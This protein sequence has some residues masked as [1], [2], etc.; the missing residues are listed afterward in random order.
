M[1]HIIFLFL[2][3]IGSVQMNGQTKPAYDSTLAKKLGADDYGMKSYIMVL[4]K[5]GTYKAKDKKESD[6]LFRGHMDNII[7]LANAGKLALAGP[8]GKNDLYRGVFIFN[9][10]TIDEAKLLCEKDPAIKINLFAVDY[11]PWYGSAA[12]ME[13]NNIHKTIEKKSH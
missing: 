1:K 3:L 2:I 7:S 9:V 10:K 13:V 12:V 8:F 5:S 4:L 6:S 11:L